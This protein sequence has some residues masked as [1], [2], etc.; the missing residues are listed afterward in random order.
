MATLR[1]R[2]K[3]ELIRKIRKLEKAIKL[4]C[5]ACVG[6]YKKF[7]CEIEDCSLYSLRPWAKNNEN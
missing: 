6:G 5:Y 7:D 3:N 4:H 2:S 1:A